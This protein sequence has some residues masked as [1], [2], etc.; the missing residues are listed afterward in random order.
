MICYI[1]CCGFFWFTAF[2]GKSGL[3]LHGSKFVMQALYLNEESMFEWFESIFVTSSDKSRFIAIVVSTF[4][5]IFVLLLSQRFTTKRERSKL[6][7]EKIEEMYK[8]SIDYS[9]AANQILKDLNNPK[10]YDK[11]GYYIID[12]VVYGNMNDSIRKMEM[13][14]GLYF[15]KIEFKVSD[16][17]IVNMPIVNI[18]IK[19][20]KL[21]EGEAYHIYEDSRNYIINAEQKITKLCRELIRKYV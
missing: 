17:S 2:N 16:Y 6:L 20:K 4:V 15:P 21:N 8:V 13:L 12:Q 9:S 18:A 10:K 7:I 11:N 14:C 5:A 3:S 1:R 19:G